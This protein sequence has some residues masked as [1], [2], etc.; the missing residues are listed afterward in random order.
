MQPEIFGI[1]TYFLYLSVLFSALA[2][3]L[4]WWAHRYNQNVLHALNL[5]LTIMIVGFLGARIFHVF[6]ESPEIYLQD[7]KLIF[8]IW[9]GGFVFYGG[10]IPAF[11][12]AALYVKIYKLDFATWAD[13][14]APIAAFA[15]GA[16]RVA[17][18]LSGC[19]YGKTCELP[20]AINGL[21]PTQAYAIVWELAVFALLLF[22]TE[23]KLKKGTVFF[24]WITLHSL[25]RLMME[26]FR[27]DFRGELFLSMSISSWISLVILSLGFA[28]L[29]G[30][31]V[32]GE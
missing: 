20:W 18:L 19:C 14:W 9:Q 21:H 29:S 31:G 1:P 28:S 16:G 13:F 17:C 5:A 30:R 6:F 32:R 27:D 22:L 4:P 25:G 2:F 15:Y 3:L 12:A 24:A 11:L 23:R 26:Y 8:L 10:A 7:P